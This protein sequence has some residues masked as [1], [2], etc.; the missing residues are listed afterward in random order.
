MKWI[1]HILTGMAVL[2]VLIA[3]ALAQD[4]GDQPAQRGRQMQRARSEPP[5]RAEARRFE[6]DEHGRLN[7]EQRRALRRTQQA[8]QWMHRQME[9]FDADKDG[10]LSEAE[11]DA[12]MKAWEQQ[13][14]K[15]RER[16]DRD[17]DGKL[18]PDQRRAAAA[19]RVRQ[20][21]RDEKRSDK[22]GRA[23]AKKQGKVPG[24]RPARARLYR[25]PVFGPRFD[26]D[27][28]RGRPGG[29]WRSAPQQPRPPRNRILVLQYFDL[30]GNGTLG[31]IEIRRGLR[32]CHALQSRLH[33]WTP[34][35]Q[36]RGGYKQYRLIPWR[37]TLGR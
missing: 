31:R 8:Q 11:R 36:W 35:Q 29:Q 2:F 24:N 18:G 17:K 22:D 27:R 1:P 26:R 19:A 7:E 3:P 9:K 21:G 4:R 33:R 32:A 37:P 13:Q 5:R 12:A 16:F 15:L 23:E 10:R 14:D 20:R 34:G 6:E 25:G 28:G 30:D